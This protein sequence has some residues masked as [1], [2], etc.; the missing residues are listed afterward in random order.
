M[1]FLKIYI[2]HNFQWLRLNA[3]LVSYFCSPKGLSQNPS[4]HSGQHGKAQARHVTRPGHILREQCKS[5]QQSSPAQKVIIPEQ[6]EI[7]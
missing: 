4:R 3:T 6:G 2:T 7:G 5:R 1:Y